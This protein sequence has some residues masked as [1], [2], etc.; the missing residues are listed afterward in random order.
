MQRPKR[1]YNI[2]MSGHS[3]DVLYESSQI[4][5]LHLHEFAPLCGKHSYFRFGAKKPWECTLVFCATL[6]C[7]RGSSTPFASCCGQQTQNGFR[8]RFFRSHLIHRRACK[9]KREVD[10]HSIARFMSPSGE[11]DMVILREME[12]SQRLLFGNQRWVW[13]ILNF[14]STGWKVEGGGAGDRWH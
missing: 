14:K 4:V 5:S 10:L 8:Q 7:V 2:A 1:E 11:N 13:G 12:G 3:C 9:T 6:P